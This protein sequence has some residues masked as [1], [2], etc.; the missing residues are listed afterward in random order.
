MGRFLGEEIVADRL[1]DAGIPARNGLAEAGREP[2][3]RLG[4]GAGDDAVAEDIVDARFGLVAAGLP[5][6]PDFRQDAAGFIC[7]CHGLYSTPP[8]TITDPG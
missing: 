1:G 5:Q 3:Q 6:L 4:L 8:R 7:V 2:D